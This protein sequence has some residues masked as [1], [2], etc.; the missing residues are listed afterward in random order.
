MPADSGCLELLILDSGHR[1][2]IVIVARHMHDLAIELAPTRT[3]AQI[4][5]FAQLLDRATRGAGERPSPQELRDFGIKL[6]KLIVRDTV[7]EILT[8]LPNE[9]IRIQIVSTHPDIQSIRWEYMQNPDVAPGPDPLRSVVRVVPT[10]GLKIPESPKIEPPVQVLFIW[11]E[12]PDQDPIGWERVPE[13]IRRAFEARADGLCE[14]TLVEAA[15]RTAVV[16]ALDKRKYGIVHF[17]CHGRV[18]DNGTGSLLLEDIKGTHSDTLPFDQ[19]AL[20]LRGREPRLVV[21]SACNTS[22]GNF[23]KP[24][25]VIARDLV[26][27]GIPA[28]V[29][30]QFAVTPSA[31]ATFCTALYGQLVKT[32]DVD[33]AV[34]EGRRI[35]ALQ[36][37][38][39]GQALVEWGIPTLYRHVDGAK[40]FVL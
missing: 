2:Q 21:L 13:T 16:D 17:N 12:P 26:R 33:W 8:S 4:A 37:S 32:G 31:V 9:P 27:N 23:A 18:E 19:L 20:A 34:S 28:V 39:P 3:I 6:F 40:V 15:T 35:L 30:N 25:A 29:A 11:A 1:K 36:P 14:V 5:S 7:K 24:W 38:V 22:S 10:I